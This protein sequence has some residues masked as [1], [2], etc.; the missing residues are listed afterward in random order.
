MECV[1]SGHVGGVNNEKYLHE[2]EIYFTK[3]PIVSLCYSSN[4]AAA[5]T[6][7][8]FTLQWN[9]HLQH[10][11]LLYTWNASEMPL[12]AFASTPYTSFFNKKRDIKTPS[13]DS[14]WRGARMLTG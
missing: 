5:N 9:C 1:R 4:M 10:E 12:Q 7:Y 3:E 2:N 13:P 14:L 6:L 11:I 8:Y